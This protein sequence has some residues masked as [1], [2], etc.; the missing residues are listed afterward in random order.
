MFPPLNINWMGFIC[1]V[2][3]AKIARATMPSC[4]LVV[5]NILSFSQL[6]LCS[7]DSTYFRPPFLNS[8]I[9]VFPGGS[10][11]RDAT[12]IMITAF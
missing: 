9:F 10:K 1:R 6:L 12:A 7:F 5:R 4:R 3:P 8:P 11:N 2:E